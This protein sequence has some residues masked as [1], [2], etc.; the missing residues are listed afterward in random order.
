MMEN[1]GM[2]AFNVIQHNIYTSITN[3]K[4]NTNYI[5]AF[6]SICD[7]CT[8][9]LYSALIFYGKAYIWQMYSV[10]LFSN[11]MYKYISYF[12][13]STFMLSLEKRSFIYSL[14]LKFY[15]RVVFQ[16]GRKQFQTKINFIL[17][18][19]IFFNYCCRHIQE[20]FLALCYSLNSL[21]IPIHISDYIFY[22]YTFFVS[23]QWGLF[24]K[25]TTVMIIHV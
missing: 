12:T 16:W 6:L 5:V 24:C 13:S 15:Q 25:N 20:S 21:H 7:L 18:L 9:F 17:T 2:C 4:M 11:S 23:N 19:H 22:N 10:H 3:M 1:S 14:L 8:V